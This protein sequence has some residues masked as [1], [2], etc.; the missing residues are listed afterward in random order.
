MKTKF[1]TLIAAFLLTLSAQATCTVT[2]DCGTYTFEDATSISTSVTSVN[3]ESTLI[4][5]NQN[6]VVLLR[7]EDCGT[8]VSSSCSSSG[9][10]GDGDL[11]ICDVIP[12]F[13]KPFFDCE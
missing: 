12:D 10:N 1:F 7:L 6:G 2:T 5:K 13:L 8:S 9:N 4:V 11:D 3:G